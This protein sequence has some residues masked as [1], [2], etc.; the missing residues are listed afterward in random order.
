MRLSLPM[1]HFL[2][3]H[4]DFATFML[5]EVFPQNKKE[6]VVLLALK[7]TSKDRYFNLQYE[8]TNRYF[9]GIEE[10]LDY[11]VKHKYFSKFRVKRIM[12]YYQKKEAQN[13]G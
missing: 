12:K 2:K 8:V 11:C 13:N 9:P 1:E 5:L 10:M 4:I 7:D 6:A 3:A